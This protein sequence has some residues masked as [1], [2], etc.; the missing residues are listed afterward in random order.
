MDVRKSCENNDLF[1][2][3]LGFTLFGKQLRRA[4]FRYVGN[5]SYQLITISSQM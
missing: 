1:L 2:S 4:H 3:S 5:V